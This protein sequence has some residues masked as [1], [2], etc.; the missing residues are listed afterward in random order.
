MSRQSDSNDVLTVGRCVR[1]DAADNY[2]YGWRL[3]SLSF[4][5]N[6]S[7]SAAMCGMATE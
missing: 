2:R 1:D 6:R 7:R 3:R 4:R 5:A